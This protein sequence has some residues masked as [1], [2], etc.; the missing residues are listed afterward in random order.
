MPPTGQ[1]NDGYFGRSGLDCD[2]DRPTIDMGHSEVRDD[3]REGFPVLV[4]GA[5]SLDPTLTAVGNDDDV[6][7][8]LERVAQRL[9]QYRVIIHKE[10]AQRLRG[11]LSGDH[12]AAVTGRSRGHRS[13]EG[14]SE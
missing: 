7:V 8:L 2:G 10:N 14:Q 6:S 9:E 13:G 12:S 3:R 11:S 5:K 4:G 1:Q